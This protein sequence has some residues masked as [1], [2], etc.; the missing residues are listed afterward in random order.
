MALLIHYSSPQPA[1]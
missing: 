1:G